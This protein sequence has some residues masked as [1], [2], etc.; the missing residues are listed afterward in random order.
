MKTNKINIGAVILVVIAVI[1]GI[2]LANTF[3]PDP[4][5]SLLKEHEIQRAEW[6]KEKDS[7]NTRV[8]KLLLEAEVLQ[9]RNDSLLQESLENYNKGKRDIKK[10]KDEEISNINNSDD[11]YLRILSNKTPNG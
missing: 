1:I 7:I 9:N 6:E 8:S 3:R 11:E 10:D 5:K 4:T 2:V